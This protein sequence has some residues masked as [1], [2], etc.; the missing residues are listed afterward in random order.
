MNFPN[1]RNPSLLLAFYIRRRFSLRI[2]CDAI[3]L[4]KLRRPVWY[5]FYCIV[6]SILGFIC[7][8]EGITVFMQFLCPVI[9]NVYESGVYRARLSLLYLL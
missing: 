4:L 8:V 9:V 5:L 3:K 7:I 2:Y 1:L 6:S